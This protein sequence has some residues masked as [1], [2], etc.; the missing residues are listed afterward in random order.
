MRR[1]TVTSLLTIQCQPNDTFRKER[2][3][4]PTFPSFFPSYNW[5]HDLD[6]NTVR[7]NKF[8]SKND[9]FSYRVR[10]FFL[11]LF[12]SWP[13]RFISRYLL[14]AFLVLPLIWRYGLKVSHK[15]FH[16]LRFIS[17]YRTALL[18]AV[19]R[20]C[21]R[22]D[23]QRTET[24]EFSCWEPI[25]GLLHTAILQNLASMS[26]S[27]WSKG[28]E[29]GNQYTDWARSQCCEIPRPHLCRGSENAGALT[30]IPF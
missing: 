19:C 27:I 5:T 21:W 12:N 18:E 15:R 8:R 17:V 4:A 13:L 29:I 3:M 20:C 28:F 24:W 22:S 1:A 26:V 9:K 6:A 7:N 14:V 16:A 11:A 10:L 30:F 25:S 23:I 2:Q